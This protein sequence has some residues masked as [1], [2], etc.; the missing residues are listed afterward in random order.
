MSVARDR[1]ERWLATRD[2]RLSGLPWLRTESHA[3]RTVRFVADEILVQDASTAIAHRTLVG[4]GHRTSEIAE[5]EPAAGLRRLRTP[6]LDVSDA[7]R[8]LRGQLP[9]GSVVGA[10]HV[11]MSTPHEHGGPFGPPVAVDAPSAKLISSDHASPVRVTVM[12]TGIWLN[13]PLPEGCYTATPE[14]HETVTDGDGDGMLDSDV[15]HANFIAGVVAQGTTGAQVR[16]VKVL[17]SF[18]VCTEADLAAA[19][20]ALTDTDVL[21]LSLGGYSIGDLPPAALSAALRTFLA[22]GDRVVVAAAGNNGVADRP[23]WPAAFTAGGEAWADRLLAVAAHDGT[24]IC[25]W[26]NTGP[27]VS[28]AAPGADVVSTYI[29]HDLFSS[30]WA[31]WS[32]TSFATPKVV[33]AVVD[34]VATAGSVTAAAAAVRAEAQGSMVGGYPALH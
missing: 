26:S 8:R 14:N 21:N 1:L 2:A 32:G 28:V 31:A 24:A 34:R 23:F 13:S 3:G 7:V 33:A 20:T 27:W 25:E 10:N 6:G 15:G 22:G 18:G 16:I 30:G 17:D 12:D 11:F 4:L 5:D 9:Q 29:N 19:I